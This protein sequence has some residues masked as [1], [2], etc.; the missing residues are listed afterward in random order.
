[1]NLLSE[2]PF[3]KKSQTLNKMDTFYLQIYT[4]FGAHM[5]KI[6][7]LLNIFQKYNNS[8]D[9]LWHWTHDGGSINFQIQCNGIIHGDETGSLPAII[10]II[11]ELE[12]KKRTFGGRLSIILGNPEATMLDQRFV[13]KDLNR[14]FLKQDDLSHEGKRARELMPI[15]AQADLL[16]DLHQTILPSNEA[17]YIFPYNEE[18]LAWARA[19]E[20]SRFYV[21]ATPSLSE[22]PRYQCADDFVWRLGAPSIT[23]ELGEKGIREDATALA[24]KAIS[25]AL[26]FVEEIHSRKATISEIALRSPDIL[27]YKT[28]HREPYQSQ[29]YQLRDGLI[30]FT[31]VTKGEQLSAPNTPKLLAPCDGM[32]LFPKYPRRKA[33]LVCESL[34]KEIYRIIVKYVK[35]SRC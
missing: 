9:Y 35:N 26:D 1:M 27:H 33:G 19:L 6:G 25:R 23:I 16:I 3:L 20:C 14:L 11:E 12:T 31:T 32:L 18:S 21:D 2:Y 28:S 8:S 34:P 7:T 10:R 24:Y 30:N 29:E 13:E 15:L 4:I 22:E 5:K 17:F